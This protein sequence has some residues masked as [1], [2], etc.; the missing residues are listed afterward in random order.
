M[1]VLGFEDIILVIILKYTGESDTFSIGVCTRI[2]I[3]IGLKFSSYMED[4]LF[5]MC[6]LLSLVIFA[7]CR[8]VSRLGIKLNNKSSD[9]IFWVVPHLEPLV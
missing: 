2:F 6:N 9:S 8:R 3:H 1:R 5:E 4:L 7:P